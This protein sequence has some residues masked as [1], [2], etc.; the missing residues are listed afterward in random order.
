MA[1]KPTLP[2]MA[3]AFVNRLFY[4]RKLQYLLINFIK[5]VDMSMEHPLLLWIKKKYE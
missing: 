4:L 5:P 3:V 1:S 2:Y